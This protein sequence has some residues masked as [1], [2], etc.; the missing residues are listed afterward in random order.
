MTL[1]D[2][3]AALG[4]AVGLAARG[5]RAIRIRDIE[6]GRIFDETGLR[7]EIQRVQQELSR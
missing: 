1:P 7:A 6:S 4:W 5:M 2:A 3:K